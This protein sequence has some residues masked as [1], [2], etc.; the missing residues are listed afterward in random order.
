VATLRV[1]G[2]DTVHVLTLDGDNVAAP[3][4][5]DARLHFEMLP[6]RHTVIAQ[7]ADGPAAPL[8]FEAEAGKIYR[9]VGDLRVFEVDRGSDTPLRDV[10]IARE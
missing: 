5:S 3:V 7:N 2:N 9:I 1:D 4:A 6:T 10:T 8:A